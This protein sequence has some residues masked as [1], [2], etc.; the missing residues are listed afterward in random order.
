[1]CV[2]CAYR[3]H[4]VFIRGTIYS[5]EDKKICERAVL[6]GVIWGKETQETVDKSLDELERLLDTAGG[7]CIARLTQ[8]KDA[9]D[10]RTVLGSGKVAE[11]AYLC[12]CNDVGLVVFD[13]ELS[14]SQ[15]RNIEGIVGDGVSVIDRSMLILDIFALH[16]VTG[17][18]KLQV[19][20]AQLKYTA[21][22]L[23]GRGTELSRLGGGIGTRGPGEAQLEL[24]RRHMQRRL[25]ALEAQLDELDK[26]RRTQRASR[27]RSGITEIAIVGYTNAGKSTL[28]NRLTDAG[29]LAEDKLFATLDTTTRK[30][31]LPCGETVLLTDTVGFINKLPHHLVKAFKSTLDEV[32]NADIIMVVADASDPDFRMELDVTEQLLCDLGAAETPVLYVFNKCDRGILELGVIGREAAEDTVYISA[33]TGQGIERLTERLETMVMNGKRRVTYVIPN[34]EAGVLNTLYKYATV[35]SV[36]YGNTAITAVALADSR[37]RGLLRRFAADGAE[38]TAEMDF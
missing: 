16:A 37:A 13:C 32:R 38:D 23:V 20:L 30:F 22:R 6:V 25:C 18:G 17:E 19:E 3:P 29:I 24:D 12:S 28:L 26:N 4:F 35:E 27:G 8:S 11:L 5:M 10:V 31:T 2:V 21:P 36:E 7:E 33:L 34:G 15:I 1:M 14:P 9:P